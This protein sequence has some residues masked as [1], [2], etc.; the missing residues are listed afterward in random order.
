M[1]E[2]PGSKEAKND[3]VP[4]KVYTASISANVDVSSLKIL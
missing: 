3:P 2:E 4:L 1:V